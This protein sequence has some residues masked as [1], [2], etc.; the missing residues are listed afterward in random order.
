MTAPPQQHAVHPRELEV[1]IDTPRFSLL[2]RKDDGSIDYV[3]PLPC[4]FNYGSVPDTRSGDGDRLDAV[5]L[6][7]RLA[8]GTRVRVQVVA[9]V[10]FVDAGEADPKY[11]CSPRPWGSRDALLVAGFFTVYARLKGA[12]NRLRGKRGPTRYEGLQ[13]L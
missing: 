8:R 5:V 12:L 7:E 13:R 4:P 2:K 9:L 6:G 3:S 10:R 11:V 1:V